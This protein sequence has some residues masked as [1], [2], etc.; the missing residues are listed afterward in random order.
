[1]GERV[2]DSRR[3]WVHLPIEVKSR[4]LQSRLLLACVAAERGYGAVLGR[5]GTLAGMADILPRGI[6]VEKSCQLAGLDGFRTRAAL[7]HVE[8][9]LDEEGVV[10]IDAEDYTAGRLS[11]VPLDQMARFFAWGDDQAAVV[12]RFHTPTISR[13]R[14]TGNP[15]VDLW[16][17]ELRGVHERQAAEIR[18]QHGRFVLIATAFATVN[19]ARGEGYFLEVQ[20]DNG[21]L[22]SAD[23][24]AKAEAY[25]E[26]SG[27]IFG[28]M[29]DTVAGLARARPDLTVVV[30][31]HPSEDLSVWE[32]LASAQPNL[33]VR[34]EGSITPWLL[35]A[36]AVVHNNS[37]S[38]L[39]AALLGRPTIAFVPRQ[40]ARFDQNLPNAV[41]HAAPTLEALIDHVD[42]ALR[43]GRL[44][45][46]G[47]GSQVL[48]RHITALDGPLAA[49]R[50]V[51]EFDA[52]DVGPQPLA[53]SFGRRVQARVSTV[54]VRARRLVRQLTPEARTAA[55]TAAPVRKPGAKFPV[56]SR[57]EIVEFIAR[58]QAVSGRFG[59]IACQELAPDVYA[60]AAE[61]LPRGAS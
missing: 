13:I 36:D 43:C 41:S 58:L 44:P 56:S 49:E 8:C 46:V 38:G 17:P 59:S 26:Y 21:R 40:D 15:R 55:A 5:K 54:G 60:I 47:P 3:P 25:I 50:L 57:S 37:T 16:R 4:E 33:G 31:P 35:A 19:N 42:V 22:A 1:M 14:V 11:A 32:D 7:G 39:E 30:R 12:G 6:Y 29:R 9:C 52:L 18:A 20:A 23:G 51:D 34:R 48:G 28:A 2:T 27:A 45:P 10:Y 61:P 24:R 53:D